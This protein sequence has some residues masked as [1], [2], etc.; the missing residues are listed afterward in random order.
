MKSFGMSSEL[1]LIRRIQVMTEM[2]PSSDDKSRISNKALLN[3]QASLN[4]IPYAGGFLATYFGEIRGKRIVERMNKYFRYFVKR[5]NELDQAKIDHAYLESEEFAELFAQGAEQA[6][7]STTEKRIRRF[8]NILANQVQIDSKSRLRTQSI[9]TFVDR[10]ND[11]DAFV[12][13]SYGAT[14]E[15]PMRAN[16]KEEA[17]MFVEKLADYLDI[18]APDKRDIIESVIYM[19]NLGLTWVNEKVSDAETEKGESLI[20]KEFSS[21]RTPL[22][23]EVVKVITP[24]NFFMPKGMRKPDKV[25]PENAVNREF[26]NDLFF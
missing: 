6:A 25:W 2:V 4:L 16:T 12:L 7:K 18:S 20:L 14:Y 1:K 5:L 13:V 10:L 11:L 19:D 17:C 15:M 24:P 8:A 22:G 21:F 26:K 9:M 23:N 3:I